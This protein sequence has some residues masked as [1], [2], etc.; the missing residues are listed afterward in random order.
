MKRPATPGL[1]PVLLWQNP[2]GTLDGDDL[3]SSHIARSFPERGAGSGP[4][5]GRARCQEW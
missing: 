4:A 5:G 3:M 1:D 2:H